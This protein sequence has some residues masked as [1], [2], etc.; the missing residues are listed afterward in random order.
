MNK[1]WFTYLFTK[2]ILSLVTNLLRESPCARSLGFPR[3]EKWNGGLVGYASSTLQGIPKFLF[4]VVKPIY[5]PTNM[6]VISPSSTSSPMRG[7]TI[8]IEFFQF[9][10]DTYFH[11]CLNYFPMQ[12]FAR[13]LII[14]YSGKSLCNTEILQS[15]MRD[16][17]LNKK[18]NKI[19]EWR[20]WIDIW[21]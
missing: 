18:T 8:Y 20:E 2:W 4:K 3:T 11:T 17:F 9:L 13:N 15:F 10:I 7:I 1:P 19:K 14:S 21:K 16:I 6:Y 5:T 12:E